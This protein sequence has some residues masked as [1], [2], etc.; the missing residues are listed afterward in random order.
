MAKRRNATYWTGLTD[1]SKTRAQKSKRRKN[2]N[3]YKPP[4]KVQQRKADGKYIGFQSGPNGPKLSKVNQVLRERPT[5]G[6][7]LE[8]SIAYKRGRK[9]AYPHAKYG[10]RIVVGIKCG[11]PAIT[12]TRTNGENVHRCAE[13]YGVEYIDKEGEVHNL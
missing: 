13:H 12:T 4:A 5:C 6:A 10:I 1:L 9:K 3:D 2:P 11:V 8:G 7:M